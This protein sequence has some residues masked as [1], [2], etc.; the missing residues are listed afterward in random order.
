MRVKNYI[1]CFTC[2]CLILVGTACESESDRRK[3][4]IE[5]LEKEIKVLEEKE[6]KFQTLF[7]DE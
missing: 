7:G 1:L 4:R 2:V 6:A 5:Q 3:A